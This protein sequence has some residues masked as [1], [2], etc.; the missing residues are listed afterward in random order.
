VVNWA[1]RSIASNVLEVLDIA[2]S[3]ERAIEAA[4][5]ARNWGILRDC[6]IWLWRKLTCLNANIIRPWKQFE[7]QFLLVRAVIFHIS[8]RQI[9]L[10]IWAVQQKRSILPNLQ[11]VFLL[12]THLFFKQHLLLLSTAVTD[13]KTRLNRP[14]TF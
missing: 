2:F 1:N 5:K 11:F 6:L 9:F 10:H 4:Q 7:R 13:M 12:F 3:P 14:K 8:P